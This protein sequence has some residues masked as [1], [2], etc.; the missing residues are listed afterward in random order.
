MLHVV[1]SNGDTRWQKR[2]HDVMTHSSPNTGCKDIRCRDVHWVL[3]DSPCGRHCGC[4][5]FQQCPLRYNADCNTMYV[6]MR[7]NLPS[8]IRRSLGKK[9]NVFFAASCKLGKSARGC[10]SHKFIFHLEFSHQHIGEFAGSFLGL[11]LTR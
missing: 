3:L 4:S 1:L 9:D 11:L 6:S 10:S 8:D 5:M 7:P 2:P